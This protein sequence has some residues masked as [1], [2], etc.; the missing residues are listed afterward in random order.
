MGSECEQSKLFY[1]L[2]QLLSAV[3]RE[4]FAVALYL[5]LSMRADGYDFFNTGLILFLILIVVRLPFLNSYA[6][7]FEATT[8]KSW[9]MKHVGVQKHDNWW[10]NSL[11]TVA[12]LVAHILAG[13]AAAAF[14]VY[15]E[16]AFGRENMGR[17]GRRIAGACQQSVA[18]CC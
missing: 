16:V 17:S 6:F 2:A 4:F 15:Y 18:R 3:V 7:I 5:I 14:K 11:H 1:V 8:I 10:Y 12:I 13:I 9:D